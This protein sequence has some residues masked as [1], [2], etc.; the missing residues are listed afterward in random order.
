MAGPIWQ[1]SVSSWQE[2]GARSKRLDARSELLGVEFSVGRSQGLRAS[3]KAGGGLELEQGVCGLAGLLDSVA[4]GEAEIL[5]DQSGVEPKF[6]GIGR[7]H[8][9]RWLTGVALGYHRSIFVVVCL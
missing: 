8:C 1:S 6:Y 4:E 7:V 9:W 5:L 2:P 3:L